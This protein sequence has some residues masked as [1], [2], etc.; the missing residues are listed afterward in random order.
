MKKYSLKYQNQKKRGRKKAPLK[1]ERGSEREG[2]Q[3][4][5]GVIR[6]K[7][8]TRRKSLLPRLFYSKYLILNIR[9]NLPN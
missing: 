6:K 8:A 7:G 9:K 4:E 5:K 3:K 1:R 2:A